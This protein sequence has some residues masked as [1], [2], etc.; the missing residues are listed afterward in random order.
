MHGND[1][2][3]LDFDE[4]L[5]SLGVNSFDYIRM[6]HL[7]GAVVDERALLGKVYEF[8]SFCNLIR[9]SVKADAGYRSLAVP[10][11]GHIEITFVDW[12][13]HAMPDSGL[14]RPHADLKCS[15]ASWWA[16]SL[17]NPD[18]KHRR[19]FR[20][21][22]ADP[23]PNDCPLFK[24]QELLA[25]AS[26]KRGIPLNP[27]P[28][29]TDSL[30]VSTGFTDRIHRTHTLPL[31]TWSL[32][33]CQRLIGERMKGLLSWRSPVEDTDGFL[34]GLSLELLTRWLGMIPAAV[35]ELAAQCER[36]VAQEEHRIYVNLH[37][38]TARK[39]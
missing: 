39:P 8:V 20:T 34:E 21:A 15:V 37:T 24:L 28:T 18:T 19:T 9:E 36:Y 22:N 17:C 12:V 26:R 11:T 3:A 27:D 35:R 23:L 2:L 31:S 32:D 29:K 13:R 30:L 6:A 4:D 25:I 7:N 38:F 16:N 1:H 33:R 10:G 14:L 5:S